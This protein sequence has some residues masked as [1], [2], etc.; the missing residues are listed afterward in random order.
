M[1]SP[2]K[3]GCQFT[4]IGDCTCLLRNRKLNGEQTDARVK[5]TNRRSQFSS[6]PACRQVQF[7]TVWGGRDLSVF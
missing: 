4:A 5:P 3:L 1:H 6:N 2:R 7:S